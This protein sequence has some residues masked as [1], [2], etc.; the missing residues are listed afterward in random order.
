MNETWKVV[1]SLERAISV[2]RGGG[3]CKVRIESFKPEDSGYKVSGDYVLKSYILFSGERI[4][5]S[6][7]FEAVLDEE[8]KVNSI[9]INPS[10]PIKHEGI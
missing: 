5:E 6:G 9:K 1:N 3:I 4:M 8:Y 2:F 7:K 10:K